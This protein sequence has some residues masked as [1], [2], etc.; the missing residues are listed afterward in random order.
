[1]NICDSNLKL[2][3]DQMKK[4]GIKSYLV[5]ASDNNICEYTH[6]Y[7]LKER[8]LLSSFTGSDGT[9]LVTQ[10]K[11]YLY[12]DGRYFTQANIEL[13]GTNTELVKMGEEGVPTIYEF[14]KENKLEPLAFDFNR[15]STNEAN[16]FA[17]FDIIDKSY[18]YLIQ[19]KIG[20]FDVTKN[21]I[22]KL[23]SDL[24]SHS[25]REKISK[26]KTKLVELGCQAT[27]IAGLED[28]A[29]LLNL[30]SCDVENTPVF[31]SFLYV[32]TIEGE[33]PILFLNANRKKP[34]L[35]D[36]DVNLIYKKT[37]DIDKY[38][39]KVKNR[40][41]LL[42]PA[43]VNFHLSNIF[44]NKLLKT[45]PT[46]LMKAVKGD[47]EIENDKL[48]HIYDGIAMLKLIN[49]IRENIKNNI[50]MDEVEYAT[51]LKEFRL[52]NKKCYDL[53]FPTISGYKENGAIIHYD[54]NTNPSPKK[55]DPSTTN[56]FLLVD[57]GGQYFGGTTDI[58]RTFYIGQ[59]TQKDKYYYTLVLKSLIN[60]SSTIFMK[61]CSGLSIDIKAREVMW[62]HGL[63]Y[64]HGTGHG[65]GYMLSVH[66]GPNGF[67]YK[68]VPERND[69]AILEP[70]MITTIEPGIYLENNLGIRLENELLT[71]EH[72]KIGNDTY[73][74][75][76]TITYCPF[77]KNLI[78]ITMLTKDEI[79]FLN[80]YHNL[81]NKQLKRELKDKKLISLLDE[82]T[83]EIA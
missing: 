47:K 48:A 12:T 76:E 30:R 37:E 20:N 52:S 11:A 35:T 5:F 51:R 62:K 61:G 71:V 22:S 70:G 68:V 83:A 43:R 25:S 18:S 8:L 80:S 72:S 46:L 24:Y 21:K 55:V 57:S 65:V 77:D 36:D 23:T 42:D 10:D 73:Y 44:K 6:P 28:I 81:V 3:Q 75:F 59:P 14:I 54:P 13:K 63:D 74:A 64:K 7:F 34:K 31:Y 32:S 27:L 33:D 15:I 38:L 53:S 58:T 50:T 56:G 45:S 19:D 78:D 39:K 4:D 82:L 67:R 66:E 26:L 9:L 2:I 1:M 40:K 16:N 69:S 79:E 29:Y 17:S 41:T 60:L 49:L